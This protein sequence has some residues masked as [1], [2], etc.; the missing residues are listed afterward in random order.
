MLVT[1]YFLGRCGWRP[2]CGR[3]GRRHADTIGRYR[4]GQFYAAI[5]GAHRDKDKEADYRREHGG[6]TFGLIDESANG[7]GGWAELYPD[8][9]GFSK[10]RDGTCS[11]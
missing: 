2:C 11:T 5:H 4:D 8:R 10:P 6:V 7:R 1:G 9:L 3:S